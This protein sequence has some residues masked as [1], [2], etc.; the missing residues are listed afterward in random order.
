[1]KAD[2]RMASVAR[3]I[4]TVVALLALASPAARADDV[5]GATVSA[6]FGADGRLWR[7]VPRGAWLEVD[8]SDDRGASF[9]AP[10][11]VNAKRQ[12]VRATPED[13]PDIAVDDGRRVFVTWAADARQPW[14]RYAAWSGDGGR[15]FSAAAAVSDAADRALQYQT[16]VQAVPGGARVFWSDARNQRPDGPGVGTLM[17][18]GF[19]TGGWTTP[20]AVSV[21]DSTCECC[22]LAVT[23]A[24]DGGSAL[25][26]RLVIDGVRDLGLVGVAKD[27]TAT[28]RRVT[29]DGWA[30]D[31]CP[32]HGPS[33]AIGPGGRY[34]YA[35]FTQ[36]ARRQGLFYAHADGAGGALSA[37]VAIG[38]RGRLA[39]HGSVGAAGRL[40]AVAWQE[41][42]GKRKSVRAMLSRDDGDT[43]EPAVDVASSS[44]AAD[45]PF[46]L[47]DGKALFVSWYAADGGYR[48]IPLA[49]PAAP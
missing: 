18:A 11:R 20:A 47:S 32:E 29:D 48:L 30:I 13:R 28:T 34:H 49:G 16:V 8:H 14:T 4:A 7:A 24:P 9:S 44:S 40:V 43:W 19:A 38:E 21:N 36:G 22:R 15:T 17:M 33:L 31:A 23:R 37:P 41:F 2:V 6:T 39:G 26:V 1:M 46:V 45:Y 12:R 35:W 25:F 5:T 10:V 42:D 27:G 3:G